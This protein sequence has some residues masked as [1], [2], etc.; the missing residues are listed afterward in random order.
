MGCHKNQAAANREKI[1]G[2]KGGG[3]AECVRSDPG[4]QVR[5][6][7]VVLGAG[8]LMDCGLGL[9]LGL[10]TPAPTNL[11]TNYPLDPY[12]G[13]DTGSHALALGVA[14]GCFIKLQFPGW[15]AFASHVMVDAERGAQG[16]SKVAIWRAAFQRAGSSVSTT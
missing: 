6:I 3:V 11:R 5:E 4:I 9:L 1:Q 10:A 7:G 14:H 8:A 13:T 16:V 12:D 15:E 2:A